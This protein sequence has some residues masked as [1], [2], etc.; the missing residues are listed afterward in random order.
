[1]LIGRAVV[2][3]A[4]ALRR[5][6]RLPQCGLGRDEQ[7]EPHGDGRPALSGLYGRSAPAAGRLHA[8]TN[9]RAGARR[10]CSARAECRR[11]AAATYAVALRERLHLH[12]RLEPAR[13]E[14]EHVVE[15]RR[16]E[17]AIVPAPVQPPLRSLVRQLGREIVERPSG[18][19]AMCA[20]E[21][22]AKVTAIVGERTR[23][24]ERHR[25]GERARALGRPRNAGRR[26]GGLTREIP[27]L[28]GADFRLRSS[29]DRADAAAG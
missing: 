23:P 26:S 7:P 22:A 8:T 12:E 18:T 10:S 24:P 13:I 15:Q 3:F 27:L 17:A 28:Y 16:D 4:G 14:R 29:G 6:A 9:P 20:P 5:A 2:A 1:M 19:C 21:V 25:P 11:S